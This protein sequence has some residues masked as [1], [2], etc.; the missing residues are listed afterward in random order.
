[1]KIIETLLTAAMRVPLVGGIFRSAISGLQR[2]MVGAMRRVDK[3]YV[4]PRNWS[5]QELKKFSGLFD[6]EIINVSGWR[7]EDKQGNHYR[8]YFSKASRYLVSNY[9]G[10]RG[11][12]GSANEIFLDLEGEIPSEL[13]GRFQVA[14]NHT[15]LEHV[16]NIRQAVANICALSHDAVILVTPFLQ[17]VHYEEGSYGDYWRPTPMALERMLEDNGFTVVHQ[18]CNDNPW[19]IVYVFTV[20]VRDPLHHA[21]RLPIITKTAR[22]LGAAH[23]GVSMA[24]A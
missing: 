23:F 3:N 18:T 1:M 6:G 12:T 2:S 11:S 10:S 19:Y 24:D 9:S 8:D 4:R 20:A 13:K 7:D 5:N 14:F 21:D 22:H 16:F 17:Q 15:V